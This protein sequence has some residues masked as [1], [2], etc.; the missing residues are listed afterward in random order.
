MGDAMS[1]KAANIVRQAPLAPPSLK[2]LA[3]DLAFR[4]NDHGGSIY[5]SVKTIAASVGVSKSQAQRLLRKLESYG[6]LSVVG[7]KFGGKPGTTRQYQL[8]LDRFAKLSTTGR[9]DEP[10]GSRRHPETGRM[11]ANQHVVDPICE[12]DMLETNREVVDAQAVWAHVVEILTKHGLTESQAE[13][14]L[15]DKRSR[16]PEHFSDAL[17]VLLGSKYRHPQAYL[18]GILRKKPSVKPTPRPNGTQ[19]RMHS[20]E[21]AG[22]S[23]YSS[24]L[25]T[26]VERRESAVIGCPPAFKERLERLRSGTG[27]A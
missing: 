10:D 21:T 8:H 26:G 16:H 27:L 2:L 12:T 22:N 1:A 14:F 6:L 13:A 9:T 7:N 23:G 11:G 25:L 3:L 19:A 18:D 17:R 15:T 24:T 20:Q 4:G 5:P